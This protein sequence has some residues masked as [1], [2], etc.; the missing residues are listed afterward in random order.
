[1][2]ECA[3]RFGEASLELGE[4][5]LPLRE[6]Y[7][8]P[9]VNSLLILIVPTL[10]GHPLTYDPAAQSP[11]DHLLYG[12]FSYNVSYHSFSKNSAYF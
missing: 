7:L 4:G 12:R 11:P 10:N 8:P 3:S 2:P 6:G 5:Y 1:M 9:L